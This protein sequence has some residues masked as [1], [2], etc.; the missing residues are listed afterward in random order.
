VDR[1]LGDRDP[2]LLVTADHGERFDGAG[3]AID[4][5]QAL[6]HGTLWVPLLA[7][8]GRVAPHRV[9][10]AVSLLDLV[11]TILDL[12]GVPARA[13]FEGRSLVPELL[14]RRDDR[15]RVVF[16]EL[17]RAGPEVLEAVGARRG[18]T[19]LLVDRLRGV[20]RAFDVGAGVREVGA[21]PA[22]LDR[23]LEAHVARLTGLSS[24]PGLR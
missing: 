6:E 2:L 1:L 24:S 8:L 12:V 7:K 5:G 15:A 11:P 19:L 9:R 18:R 20:R 10:G 17:D 16:A 13:R 23:R 3:A 21:G 22:D 14:G 4:R